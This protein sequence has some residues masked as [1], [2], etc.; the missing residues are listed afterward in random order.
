MISYNAPYY[1]VEEKLLE[2]SQNYSYTIPNTFPDWV[3]VRVIYPFGRCAARVTFTDKENELNRVSTYLDV[4]DQ[5]G[6]MDRPYFEIYPAIG[7]DTERFWPNQQDLMY[8][9]VIASLE[10]QRRNRA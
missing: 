3:I 5:L 9:A 1:E 4:A 6:C 8:L 2:L 10:D 7:G